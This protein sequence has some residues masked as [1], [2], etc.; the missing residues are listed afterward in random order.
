MARPWDRPA[1]PKRGNRSDRSLFEAIG[2][3]LNAWEEI[4]ISMSHLYAAF[5]ASDRFE[6]RASHAY[7]E[8]GNFKQRA[9]KLER[10]AQKHFILHPSQPIEGEF[11]R[12]MYL[13]TGFS[14]R[15][16]DIAHAHILPVYFVIEPDTAQK[17]ADLMENAQW[18]LVPPHFRADKFTVK[19]RPT[20]VLTSREINEFG[21]VFRDIAHAFSNLSL[22]VTLERAPPSRGMRPRPNAL[23]YKVRDPRIRKG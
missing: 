3:T 11:S 6:P 7:G 4:E 9:A 23:P 20:Y 18:C 19:R 8:D 14:A 5:V 22:V 13:V 1:F 2:R 12:L 15:R 16:N 17:L 10:A 21:L